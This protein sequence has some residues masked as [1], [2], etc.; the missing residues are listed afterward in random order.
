V[1]DE[2][3]R[4]GETLTAYFWREKGLD[5]RI[6]RIFNTYGPGLR[7]DDKRMVVN[8]IVAA[9]KNEPI[10]IYGQG[11]QTRSLCYIDDLIEGLLRLMFYPNT[12]AEVVNLG[13]QDEHTVLFF[14]QKIKKL[15][16]SKSK[17]VFSQKL[18]EDDPIKRKPDISKAEKLLNWRPKIDLEEG[19]KK[20][21]AYYKKILSAKK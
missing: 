6:A 14:A 20:T 2:A 11:K 8:F 3:K 15:T 19:L 18:P 4:I 1:Y 13:T 21:I 12:K 16:A 17:I 7:I 9:L 10:T 5:G